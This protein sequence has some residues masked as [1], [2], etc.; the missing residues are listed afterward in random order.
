MLK[1]LMIIFQFLW[2]LKELDINK[3]N[4]LFIKLKQLIEI[5][6]NLDSFWIGIIEISL[7]FC[8]SVFKLIFFVAKLFPKK[9]EEILF[10]Y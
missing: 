2:P 8:Y 4:F 7:L 9:K 10:K 5:I 1:Y 3:D 6:Y